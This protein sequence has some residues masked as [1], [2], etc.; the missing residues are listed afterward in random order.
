MKTLSKFSLMIAL[1]AVLTIGALGF[2]AVNNTESGEKI[3][4]DPGGG[5]HIISP[6]TEVA[7]GT[8][9]TFSDPGGGGH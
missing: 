2:T 7:Y 3:S 9:G 6:E 8:V 5:G 4:M 1:V